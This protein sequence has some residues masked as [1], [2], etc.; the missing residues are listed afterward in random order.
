MG[1]DGVTVQGTGLFKDTVDKKKMTS[2]FMIMAESS[3]SS[4]VA[5]VSAAGSTI[6]DANSGAAAAIAASVNDDFANDASLVSAL[7][8]AFTAKQLTYSA[9]DMVINVT[10][11]LNSVKAQPPVTATVEVIVTTTPAATAVITGNSD[12]SAAGMAFPLA[13]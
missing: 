1:A 11:I 5:K 6:A 13:A 9:D 10:D 2:T 7:T 12:S 4:A 8:A 3:S